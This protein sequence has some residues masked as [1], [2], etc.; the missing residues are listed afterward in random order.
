MFDY[1]KGFHHDNLYTKSLVCVTL[2]SFSFTSG[3][4][5][6]R[7]PIRP[8][9]QSVVSFYK[10]RLLR[11]YPLYVASL[12][13]FSYI[14]LAR[15]KAAYKAALS[16]SIF[17]PPTV[18][19]L[20]FISMIMTFYLITPILI[21][22][23]TPPSTRSN[24]DLNNSGSDQQTPKTFIMLCLLVFIAIIAFA[25]FVNEIDVRILMYFP[26]FALGIATYK[27]ETLYKNL[28]KYKLVILATTF[29]L[30]PTYN[31]GDKA[32]IIGAILRVPI[33]TIGSLS[34]FTYATYLT[35]DRIAKKKT[36]SL[37]SKIVYCLSYSSFCIYL[38]HRIVYKYTREIYFPNSFSSQLSY[39]LIVGLGVTIL[40]SFFIQK[41][42]DHIVNR[43]R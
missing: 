38:F 36:A 22:H 1:I 39:M 5:L 28:L 9:W 12:I 18:Q 4:L 37:T 17:S 34:F 26:S 15:K 2:G 42:Y 21:M 19:T 43:L 23:K 41:A 7:T 35:T 24:P 10:H 25:I 33:I 30:L 6:A 32:T 20:W 29:A 11:V 27:Y 14:G 8:T 16:I 40:L 3:Y 13:I 31:M